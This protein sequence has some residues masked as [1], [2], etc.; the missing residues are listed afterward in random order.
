MITHSLPMWIVLGAR[1]NGVLY[2]CHN[3]AQLKNVRRNTL[4]TAFVLLERDKIRAICKFV[5]IR[6]AGILQRRGRRTTL[7]LTHGI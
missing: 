6:C 3:I 5:L 2:Q 7:L 4:H 1:L